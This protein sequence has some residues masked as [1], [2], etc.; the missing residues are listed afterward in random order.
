MSTNDLLPLVANVVISNDIVIRENK[1]GTVIA[2]KM[3]DSDNFYKIDG[4]A[5]EI[6]KDLRKNI[7]LKTSVENVSKKYN[8][9]IPTV[10][11]DVTVFLKKL[12]SIGFITLE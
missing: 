7:D 4:V 3:D 10:H 11:N 8:V 2:M 1:D 6:F 12:M 5:A 9:S